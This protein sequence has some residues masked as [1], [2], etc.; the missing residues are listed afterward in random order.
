M[1][2]RPYDEALA[3]AETEALVNLSTVMSDGWKGI[4]EVVGR[5][6]QVFYL[7]GRRRAVVSVEIKTEVGLGT[8]I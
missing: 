8:E 7:G 3:K 6:Q 5:G 4:T 1:T 2:R